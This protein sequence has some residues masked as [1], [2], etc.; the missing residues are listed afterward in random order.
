MGLFGYL[1][2]KSISHEITIKQL[3][4]TEGGHVLTHREAK[5]ADVIEGVRMVI[6]GG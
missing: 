3:L 5:K 6:A 1:K 4:R 2:K